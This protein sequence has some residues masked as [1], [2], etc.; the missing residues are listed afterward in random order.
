M[1]KGAGE[2]RAGFRPDGIAGSGTH[3]GSRAD[4]PGDRKALRI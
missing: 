4:E 2:A 1:A 3:R